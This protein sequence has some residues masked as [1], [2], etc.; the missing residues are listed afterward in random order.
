VRVEDSIIAFA[1]EVDK[2]TGASTTPARI[3]VGGKNRIGVKI[4]VRVRV[5][6]EVRVRVRV[7]VRVRVRVRSHSPVRLI[8]RWGLPLPQPA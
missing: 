5:R 4:R 3:V 8:R 2:K 6:V 1:R 7:E